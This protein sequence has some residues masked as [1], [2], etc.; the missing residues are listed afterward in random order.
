MIRVLELLI[1]FFMGR[2][3]TEAP[4]SITAMIQELMP[5]IR[6]VITLFSL[7]LGAC[8]L[9][10]A[11]IVVALLEMAAQYDRVG[12]V[13]FTASNAVGFL[14]IVIGLFAGYMGLKSSAWFPVQAQPHAPPQSHPSPAAEI[15]T[16]LTPLI[17]EFIRS[18]NSAPPNHSSDSS[19]ANDSKSESHG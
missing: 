19:A 9:I 8:A 3:Q 16:A 15:I 2:A 18:R 10:C 5:R 1:S 14:F 6:R 7:A 11:G 12:Y 17:Q 4:P 13:S